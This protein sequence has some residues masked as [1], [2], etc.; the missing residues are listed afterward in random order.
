[1]KVNI[2]YPH[3]AKRKL[4]RQTLIHLARWPF[5]FSALIVALVN[6]ATGGP[7]WSVLALWSLWMV[8][9]FLISP[10]L[11]EYNR[12]SIWIRLITYTSIL[13]LII[14]A[15][16][17]TGWSIEV[18]PNVCFCG[19]FIAGVLFF[20]DIERQQQNMMPML[21]LIGISLL[22]S[23]VGL[24]LWKGESRWA[25]IVLGAVAATLLVIC[26]VVLRHGFVREVKKR[27]HTR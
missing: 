10:D 23:A 20:T 18:V 22:S 3:V 8:W 12:I 6:M 7:A 21:T 13:L 25:L 5:L 9:S 4:Q 27:L 24:A 14:D 26:V 11:V 16:F 2:T 1:M 17:P 15:V 19:L